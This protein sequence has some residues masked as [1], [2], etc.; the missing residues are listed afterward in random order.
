MG[1][2]ER[3]IRNPRLPFRESLKGF[4][5][6][7]RV[8]GQTRVGE[9]KQFKILLN[10]RFEFIVRLGHLESEDDGANDIVDGMKKFLVEI[11]LDDTTV[12]IY[13]NGHF[14]TNY[15]MRG[16]P[17]CIDTISVNGDDVLHLLSI[18]E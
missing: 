3:I 17:A 2:P 4:P 8:E 12:S 16:N 6:R 5:Q 18:Y 7:I 14:F 11:T 1:K 9:K 10:D 13:V 15:A